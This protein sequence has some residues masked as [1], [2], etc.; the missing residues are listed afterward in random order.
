MQRCHTG[1]FTK[2]LDIVAGAAESGICRAVDQLQK[3][4]TRDRWR[5]CDTVMPHHIRNRY[6]PDPGYDHHDRYTDSYEGQDRAGR[7]YSAGESPV[8][9]ISMF[10][11]V[12]KD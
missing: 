9:Q 1:Q 4:Y 3:S 5:C 12:C 11:V 2:I 7:R 6:I 10:K 8:A